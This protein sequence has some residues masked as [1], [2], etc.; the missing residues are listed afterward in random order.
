MPEYYGFTDAPAKEDAFSIE[1][2]IKG[3]ASFIESC[4]TPMTI[5]IQ[6]SW[7]TGKTS[8]MK[9]VQRELDKKTLSIDFNTWQFSQ[10][11]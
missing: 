7:G 11:N 10:F 8:V 2:Y 9:F 1:Q 4:N 6:G 3:L 5:S